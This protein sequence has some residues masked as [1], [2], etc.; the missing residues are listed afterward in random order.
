MFVAVCRREK[1]Q[2]TTSEYDVQILFVSLRNSFIYI[3]SGEVVLTSLEVIPRIGSKSKQ[4][5][6]RSQ[7]DIKSR[8]VLNITI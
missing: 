8:K 2:I 4:I 1:N 3:L 6:R 7:F 5:M